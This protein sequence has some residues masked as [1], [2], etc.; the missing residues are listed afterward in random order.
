MSLRD[1]LLWPDARLSV[2][3]EPVGEITGEVSQLASDM[4]T[5]MYNAAGRGLAAPQIG[6]MRRIFVMDA[7]WKEGLRMPRVMINPELVSVSEERCEMEEVCLS[8]PGI[9]APVERPSRIAM[10]W[11]DL[12]GMK[13]V[14]DFDGAEARI[15][16]HELDHLNG[17]VHFDRLDPLTRTRLEDSYA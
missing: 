17:L 13:Q 8:I 16:L 2:V 1:I 7:T 15:A 6:D 4:F 12:D 14:S 9:V 3:C 11:T 10:R 5:T